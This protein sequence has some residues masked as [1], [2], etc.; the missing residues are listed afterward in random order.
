[1]EGDLATWQKHR[2]TEVEEEDD[3][4]S[5]LAGEGEAEMSPMEGRNA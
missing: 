3:A 4:S 5:L 2:I 1:M